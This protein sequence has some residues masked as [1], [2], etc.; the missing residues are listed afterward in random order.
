LLGWLLLC[1]SSRPC[2]P[3][4]LLGVWPVLL[5]LLHAQDALLLQ[6]LPQLPDTQLILLL[7]LPKLR[8]LGSA[9]IYNDAG[10]QAWAVRHL[11]GVWQMAQD[12]VLLRRPH[13]YDNAVCTWDAHCS[14]YFFLQHRLTP[15]CC[16]AA[17]ALP[18]IPHTLL[19]L[20]GTL[21]TPGVQTAAAGC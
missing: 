18:A 19:L 21:Q 2:C 20:A 12:K 9:P 3:H 16:P 1:L 6:L 15:Y 5:L 7:L 8:V 4:L 11:K 17:R 14:I 13:V 10:R